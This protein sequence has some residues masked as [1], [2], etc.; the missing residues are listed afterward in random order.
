MLPEQGFV[1]ESIER[2]P[3]WSDWISCGS[4]WTAIILCEKGSQL[5]QIELRFFRYDIVNV[6]GEE[7][8]CFDY[9]CANTSLNRGLDFRLCAGGD[10]AKSN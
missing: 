7:W 4:D 3:V 5:Q 8:V 10:A 6:R 9:F 2:N 1:I